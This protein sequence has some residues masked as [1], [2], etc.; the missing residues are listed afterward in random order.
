MIS[1]IS[2]CVC[3]GN[4]GARI[5]RVNQGAKIAPRAEIVPKTR[6]TKVKMVLARRALLWAERLVR[7][8]EYTGMNAAASDPPAMTVK[9]TSG[10]W[11]AAVK[12]SNSA[13]VPKA[14]LT[15]RMRTRPVNLPRA[16][17]I[18]TRTDDFKRCRARFISEDF[19]LPPAFS[20]GI[21]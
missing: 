3:G 14:V 4:P 12:A 8:S 20:K 11:F 1:A 6:I 13:P 10:S 21:G 2:A 7:Y 16:N 18:I 15:K 9:N 19:S 17:K 5:T